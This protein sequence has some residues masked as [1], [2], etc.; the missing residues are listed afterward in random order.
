[1]R[2]ASTKILVAMLL[3]GASST[4]FAHPGH[5]VSGFAAGLIHPFSGMDHLLAMVAVGLWAAQGKNGRRKIWLLP[6]TFMTMLVVG[7]GIAMQWQSL[8]LV[9]AGI[10]TSVLAM[11][12]LIALSLQ[13]PV[14]LSMA[15]AGV[16]G[17]MH[18]YAHGLE[19]PASAAPMEYALGFL[20]ATASLHLGGIALGAATRK[21]HAL[22]AKMLGVAIAASGAYLLASV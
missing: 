10:A 9:E 15:V 21:H 11:G 22:L 14:A 18:G 19:L 17:L 2:N 3:F 16:F 5:D 7:A 1:M 13:L 8:P 12:L 6:A 20:A 4:A